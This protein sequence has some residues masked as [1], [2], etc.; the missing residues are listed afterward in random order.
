M[1][2]WFRIIISWGFY[3][4]NINISGMVN[5]KYGGIVIGIVRNLKMREVDNEEE[6]VL[7]N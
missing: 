4:E 3:Y 1:E 7:I 5:Y 2:V 6:K